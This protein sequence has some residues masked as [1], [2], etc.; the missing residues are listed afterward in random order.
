MS[1]WQIFRQKAAAPR[2]SRQPLRF[3]LPKQGAGH[4]LVQQ[5]G[6]KGNRNA[7]NEIQGRNRQQHEGGYPGDAAVDGIA[8]GD[9]CLHGHPVEPGKGGQQINGVEKASKYRQAEGSHG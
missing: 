4:P 2:A 1:L 9:D 6:Q 3:L 5:Q 7:L 8:G